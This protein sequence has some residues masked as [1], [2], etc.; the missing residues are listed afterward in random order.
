[1]NDKELYIKMITNVLEGLSVECKKFECCSTKCDF[2]IHET[3]AC[4]L[5]QC[6]CDYDMTGISEAVSKV[7][8]KEMKG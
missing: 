1:M 2:Y 3:G 4:L 6:P 7:L 5:K 8:E